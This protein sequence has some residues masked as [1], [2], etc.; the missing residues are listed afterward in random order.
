MKSRQGTGTG[1]QIRRAL[2]AAVALWFSLLPG[3]AISWGQQGGTTPTPAAVPAARFAKRVVVIPITREIDGIMARSVER[4]I[5]EAEES[6]ADGMVF[7]LNTPGGDI[8]AMLAI[9]SAIKRSK[10]QNSV[11]WVNPAAYS[12]GA[13]IAMSCREIVISDSAAM[14]DAAPIQ[15]ILFFLNE[16]RETERQKMLGPILIEVIDSARRRGYDERLV[17]GFVSRG[18]D[19]WLVEN[20]KTGKRLFVGHDEYK[21]IM[22]Q[23]PPTSSPRV[24]AASGAVPYRDQ[25]AQE[26]EGVDQ[27]APG[28]LPGLQDERA[29]KPAIPGLPRQVVKEVTDMQQAESQRPVLSETDRGEWRLVEFVSDGNGLL[30]LRNSEL[31]RYGLASQEVKG[32]EDLRAFFGSPEL[33]RLDESWSEQLVVPLNN[34]VVKGILLVIFLVALFIEMTHPGAILPG[35]IAACALAGIVAPAL[36]ADMA[37]WWTVAAVLVGILLIGLEMFV[38]PG[39]GVAGV[40]GLL[41]L[42]AGLLGTFTASEGL[43]PD[44]ARG[45]SQLLHGATTL[46]VSLVTAGIIMFFL[47]KHLP[48]LPIIRHLVLSERFSSQPD[49]GA[50]SDG[51]LAAMGP[52]GG[53]AIGT[54]GTAV[55]P[56]RPAGRVQIGD[57]ILDVVADIGFIPS[58]AKVRITS[59]GP[60]RTTV[61]WMDQRTAGRTEPRGG[62]GE[63]G[64]TPA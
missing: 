24:P 12:A 61:E 33:V 22:G 58:G 17:Q 34:I 53:I 15:S 5:R 10:I 43:F 6:G 63:S 13:I 31:L 27:E 39:F 54:E 19:L 40:V 18:V 7:D 57:Q 20:I 26:N 47:G 38:I 4:R 64:G 50:I 8:K 3:G 49:D 2:A 11:A 14:G 36:F 37:T 60:F 29:Y 16:L 46:I 45:Q 62:A 35:A 23:D 28:P 32:E 21:L 25:L 51:L 41:M 30:T 55:T 1:I 44:T 52:E 9:C 42:F 59:T 56:L 48:S